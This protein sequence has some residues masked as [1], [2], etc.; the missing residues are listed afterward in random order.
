MKEIMVKNNFLNLKVFINDVPNV[1]IIPKEEMDMIV[2]ALEK[3]INDFV[4]QKCEN[5]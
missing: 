1:E 5:D 2:T 4:T 3:E